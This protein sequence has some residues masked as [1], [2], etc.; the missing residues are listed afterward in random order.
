MNDIHEDYRY[1]TYIHKNV[2]NS[3]FPKKIHDEKNDH[4]KRHKDDHTG[5][6]E[7]ESDGNAPHIDEYA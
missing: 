2:K 7:T 4:D 5:D 3:R 1:I 6:L